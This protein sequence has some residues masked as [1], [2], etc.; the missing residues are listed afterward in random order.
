MMAELSTS[1][2]ATSGLPHRLCAVSSRT[3]FIVK[4]YPIPEE[5]LKDAPEGRVTIKFVATQWLAGG[6]FDV[7]LMRREKRFS[8][9][10]AR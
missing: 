8:R 2:Q 6:L 4:R 1:L 10:L 7:R 5:V 9:Y 3:T